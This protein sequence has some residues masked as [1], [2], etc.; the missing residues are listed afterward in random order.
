VQC[1]GARAG[2]LYLPLSSASCP[3]G[4][5]F[6]HFK[7]EQSRLCFVVCLE[8]SPTMYACLQWRAILP[9]QRASRSYPPILHLS[10]SY[11]RL[12]RTPSR[13]THHSRYQPHGC[14]TPVRH[15]TASLHARPTTSGPPTRAHERLGGPSS[16]TTARIASACDVI[17]R[18]LMM[19]GMMTCQNTNGTQGSVHNTQGIK[20]SDAGDTPAGPRS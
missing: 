6:S 5:R 10:R 11:I 20:R 4:A 9:R 16:P 12:P 8:D 2:L 1:W 18:R 14:G 3:P 13:T 19:L 15:R 17:T 7:R